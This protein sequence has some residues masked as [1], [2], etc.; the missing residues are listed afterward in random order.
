MSDFED[1]EEKAMR[2]TFGQLLSEIRQVVAFDGGAGDQLADALKVRNYLIHSSF[3]SH[4]ESFV[5]RKGQESMV[6]ELCVHIKC[7]IDANTVLDAMTHCFLKFLGIDREMLI[8]AFEELACGD[9]N[10]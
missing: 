6:D 9:N 10:S 4:A 5:S 3:R 2:K 8:A 7:L 1:L